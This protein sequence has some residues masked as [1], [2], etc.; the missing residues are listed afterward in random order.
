MTAFGRLYGVGV[1]PGDPELLTVK[2]TKIIAATPVVAFFAKVGR[3][4]N[5]RLIV[6]GWLKSS[7]VE[8]PLYYPMTDESH[9]DDPPYREALARFYKESTIEIAAHLEAGRDVALLSEGDPMLY[10]S[11]MHVF[12]RLRERFAITIVPGVSSICGAWGVAGAPMTWG[13]D[14]LVVLPATLP[15]DELKRRLALADA[16]VIMK[17]GRNFA[18]AKQALVATGMADRA[19]YVE[20]ATMAGEIVTPLCEK[21]DDAAPYFSL[22]LAPGRGRRP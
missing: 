22:I 17:I 20:R 4:G 10:G 7:H 16:A 18:R 15:L 6:D 14:A 13:D 12:I 2:A 11:F 21:E 3:R 19:I 1:G 9:F 5:A 8:L